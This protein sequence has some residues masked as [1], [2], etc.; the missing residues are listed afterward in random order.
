MLYILFYFF[1]KLR[2]FLFFV[3][4]LSESKVILSVWFVWGCRLKKKTYLQQQKT[5]Q[6]KSK[7]KMIFE[8]LYRCLFL[9]FVI[10]TYFVFCVDILRRSNMDYF[11]YIS[12][13]G[14]FL[15]L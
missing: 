13:I 9:V 1:F 8:Y 10:Y 5:K 4:T 15:Y 12:L 14:H 6:T 3:V 2:S 7:M 11:F